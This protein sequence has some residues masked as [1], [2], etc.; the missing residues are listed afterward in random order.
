MA[1]RSFTE[2]VAHTFDNQLWKVSEDWYEENKDSVEVDE[3]IL[4]KIGELE[5][6]KVTV[7]HVW[8]EDRP[9]MRI[10]FDVAVEVEFSIGEGDYHY[11]NDFEGK[12]WL[13][14]SCEGDLDKDLKDFTI[15]DVNHYDG[16]S[17]RQDPLSDALVPYIKKT[18]LDRA[19][20]E[21]LKK[22]CPK[23]LLQPMAIDP[24]ELAEKMGL[25]VRMEYITKD[26]SIFGRT[27][28]Y[29]CNAELYNPDTDEMYTVPVKAGTIMVDKKAYF[30]YAV[31]ASHNTIVHECVH[32]EKHKKPIAL[33]RLYNNSLSSIG[34]EVVGGIAENTRDSLDWMEW[35]ANSLAPKIQMPKEMFKKYVDGLITKYRRETKEYDIIDLIEPIITEVSTTFGVSKTAAK[36]RLLEIGRTEAQGAFIY[37]DGEHIPPHK[38]GVPLEVNQTYSIGVQDAAILP[39][40]NEDLR[41]I[42]SSGIYIYVESH[43]VLNH[44]RYVEYNILGNLQLT[45][46]ARNHMD[47]CCL[48]FNLSIKNKVGKHYHSECFLN[49][50]GIGGLV[51]FEVIFCGGYQNS[52]AKQGKILDEYMEWTMKLQKMLTLDYTESMNNIMKELNVSAAA[53][54]RETELNEATIRRNISGETFKIET[55]VMILLGLHLPYS[56][57]EQIITMSPGTLMPNNSSHQWYKFTLQHLYAKKPKEIRDFLEEHGANPL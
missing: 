12:D 48:L 39:Y 37:V 32:W 8:V 56:I 14:I 33:A 16:K 44:S 3:S 41:K 23:A 46:Y 5:I 49:R 34:C 10:Q 29:D 7:M 18:D 38:A 43:Y 35:Q 2:Y 47:E 51:G 31:G 15:T 19:S 36:I 52:P 42:L 25:T 1:D 57:S 17:R 50:E 6:E 53:L 28:F 27:F 24:Y 55:L 40:Q 21:I 30:M 11:D 22:Y 26:G 4:H 45:H 20:E 13:M 54:A 9:D